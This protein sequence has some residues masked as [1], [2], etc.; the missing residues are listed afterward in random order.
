MYEKCEMVDY[1]NE[2]K[3]N[4]RTG[5]PITQKVVKIFKKKTGLEI[6]RKKRHNPVN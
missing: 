1:L 5:E 4:T 6:K 3:Y 2:R